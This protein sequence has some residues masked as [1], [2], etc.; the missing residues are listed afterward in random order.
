MAH[1]RARQ[2]EVRPGSRA[3]PRRVRPRRRRAAR[4]T[5]AAAAWILAA[6][7]ARRHTP[8]RSPPCHSAG[9]PAARY[10]ASVCRRRRRHQ[11]L[12]WPTAA[13][14]GEEA[15]RV[16]RP[17]AERAPRSGPTARRRSSGRLDRRRARDRSCASEA[18]A[19]CNMPSSRRATS[20]RLRAASLSTR[21]S[22]NNPCGRRT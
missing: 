11:R 10:A 3:W 20:L 22:A 18:G 6:A 1:M 12:V 9:E 16:P 5:R 4:R 8:P 21:R 15:R 2:G 13:A 7:A 17:S 14:G 19:A